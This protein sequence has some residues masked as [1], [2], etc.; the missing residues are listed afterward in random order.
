MPNERRCILDV[1]KYLQNC[2]TISPRRRSDL[3]SA[4]RTTVGLLLKTPT[5]QVTDPDLATIVLGDLSKLLQDLQALETYDVHITAKTQRQ[6]N[7]RFRA[8]LHLAGIAIVDRRGH[9]PMLPD[10]GGLAALT[11]A[12][13]ILI[14]ITA[15]AFKRLEPQFAKVL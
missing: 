13:L 1:C 5:S 3:M 9:A 11:V 14:A 6:V 2:T 12:S 15:I 10:W 4:V 8:A 7:C